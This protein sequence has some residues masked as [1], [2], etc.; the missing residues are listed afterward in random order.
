MKDKSERFRISQ[1]EGNMIPKFGNLEA[2]YHGEINE[3]KECVDIKDFSS[4]AS[5]I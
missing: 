1:K 4:L 5:C 3:G 2:K